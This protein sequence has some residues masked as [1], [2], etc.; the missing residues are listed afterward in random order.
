MP[1]SKIV[2]P[3]S[4]LYN[5]YW[6]QWDWESYVEFVAVKALHTGGKLQHLFHKNKLK[7][8]MQWESYLE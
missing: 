2:G 3:D 8:Y 6:I 1:N 5:R 7:Y 4:P